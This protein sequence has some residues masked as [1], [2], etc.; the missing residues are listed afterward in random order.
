MGTRSLT[1][2]T[3]EWID[4][5][6]GDIE[7][8]A[9]IYR[10]WDGYLD[11]HG[12]WLADFLQDAVVTNG[13]ID[14]VKNFNGP[15]RLASGIVAAMQTDELDPDLMPQGTICGQEYT[16]CIHV[17]YGFSGGELTVRILDGPM[18]AFGMGGE[19]CDNEVFTG[20]V[21]QFDAFIKA[22]EATPDGD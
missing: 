11:G 7:H 8:D 15:G 14:G 4:D 6:L 1:V 12:R 3:H 9:T 2:V 22:A 21:E 13:K 19:K 16:Y 20:T 10:H 17:K 18:T 5:K